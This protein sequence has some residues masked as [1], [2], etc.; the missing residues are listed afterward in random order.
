MGPGA[1]R[2]RV[3]VVGSVNWD[4][5]RTVE[6]LPAPGETVLAT[7]S[8]AAGGGKGANQAVAAASCGAPTALVACVGRDAEGDASLAELSAVGVDVS[9]V[10][11]V[12]LPTGTAVVL[13]DSLGE[14]AI[15]VDP[16]ANLSCD[17]SF[18]R[19][20]LSDLA[21]EDVVVVQAEIPLVGM[22][23]AV[24]AAQHVGARVVLNVAPVVDVG[25]DLPAGCVVVVNEHE[26]VALAELHGGGDATSLA[27]VLG[28]T[29]VVTQG[30]RGVLVVAR[31]GP[32][33]RVEAVLAPEV[34]DTTGAGDAFVGGLAAALRLNHP[35]ETA[36]RWGALAG[37]LTVRTAGARCG[38]LS[39]VPRSHRV[40]GL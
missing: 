17:E 37:S 1:S 3:V 39:S 19:A 31:D 32:S 10:G 33:A 22:L 25:T 38:D 8:S 7:S 14:N 36:A 40:C 28:A 6:R 21:A 27:R 4:L 34:V 5:V 2:G 29:V 12:G 35:V 26:A 9:A 20:A 30:A 18:V 16:G 11:R 24:R 15:V 23:S 13:V